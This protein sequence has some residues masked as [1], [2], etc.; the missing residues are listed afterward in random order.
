MW[1][2][3][4]MYSDPSECFLPIRI[5][6]LCIPPSPAPPLARE[7]GSRYPAVSCNRDVQSELLI[8]MFLKPRMGKAD[9]EGRYKV[10][11]LQV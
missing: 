4:Q 9:P 8:T 2:E 6:I 3:F 7:G 5:H 1:H 10:L 11:F